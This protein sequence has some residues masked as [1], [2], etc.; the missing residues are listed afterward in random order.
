MNLKDLAEL[1]YGKKF[2]C[3]YGYLE[4]QVELVLDCF[5]PMNIDGVEH[6][7]VST[8]IKTRVPGV[9]KR[10]SFELPAHTRVKGKDIWML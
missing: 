8:Q 7:R 1:R 5:D 4:G 3:L 10:E 6:Y 2:G 9:S